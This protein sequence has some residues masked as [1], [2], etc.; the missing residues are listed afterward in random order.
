MS[1]TIALFVQHPR[2]SVQSCNGVIKA[3]GANYNYKLFT[4]HEIEDDYFNDVDLVCLPGGVGDA[5]TY[6]HMFKY[7]EPSIRQYIEDGGRFLGI[8]MGA[9][10]AD[11]HFLDIIDSVE[12]K[13][14]IRRPNACTKRYYSKAVECN[15]QGDTDRFFFYDGP[16]FI[17][18]ESKFETIARYANG[19]PAAIIQNKIGLIGPHLEAEEYWYSKPYLHKHWHQGKHH[20]LLREFV[21]RLLEK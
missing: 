19:E 3:L 14:Y 4:K 11:K 18:N 15:W 17:G 21:N 13:Q 12:A 7:H 5:D 20:K 1:C 2:C 16:A 8:C 9:Y 10:W 6:D